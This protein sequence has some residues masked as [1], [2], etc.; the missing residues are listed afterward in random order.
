MNE[1]TNSDMI[2]EEKEG[3]IQQIHN[4]NY[5]ISNNLMTWVC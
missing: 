1:T 4:N 2:K 3:L 5:E